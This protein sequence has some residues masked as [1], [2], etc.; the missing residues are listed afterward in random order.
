MKPERRYRNNI[1]RYLR[2][3]VYYWPIN[4]T[5]TSGVPDHWYSGDADCLWV[6]YKYYPTSRVRFSLTGT[7]NPKLSALQQQWINARYAEGR[8]VWVVVGMP[9]GGLILKHRRWM[10][11]IIVADEKLLSTKEIAN[12]ILSLTAIQGS[13]NGDKYKR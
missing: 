7:K 4:D 9:S 5:Y 11:D 6:E 2:G 1:T 8:N 13:N 12:E 10:D 3:K